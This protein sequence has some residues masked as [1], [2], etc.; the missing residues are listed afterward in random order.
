MAKETAASRRRIDGHWDVLCNQIG[1][2]DAGS[3]EEQAGADYI[4]GQF[5]GLG[6]VNVRQEPFEFP[7][8]KFTRG[9]LKV[10]K[11]KPTR[12]IATARPAVHSPGTGPKGVR[13]KLAFLPPR[14]KGASEV[15]K[16]YARVKA[17]EKEAAMAQRSQ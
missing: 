15:R 10:G 5:R 3:K 2:R 6:L 4:E 1:C 13:G 8:W 14:T 9:S 16:L 17:A 7:N 11:D 12:R